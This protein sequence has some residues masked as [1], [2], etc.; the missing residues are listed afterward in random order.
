[1]ES[2]LSNDISAS[3]LCLKNVTISI[4]NNFYKLQPILILFGTL[5]AGHIVC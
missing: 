4:V 1:M 5:Y 3:T 2:T